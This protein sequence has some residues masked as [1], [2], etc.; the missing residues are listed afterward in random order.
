MT[1]QVESRQNHRRERR[2]CHVASHCNSIARQCKRRSLHW[3]YNPIGVNGSALF[4][5]RIWASSSLAK[6]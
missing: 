4:C 6:H 5:A 1:R 2:G 3:T